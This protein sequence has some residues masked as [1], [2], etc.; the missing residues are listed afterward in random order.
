VSSIAKK[1][2]IKEEDILKQNLLS[3]QDSLKT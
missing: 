3:S 2:K 1:Y